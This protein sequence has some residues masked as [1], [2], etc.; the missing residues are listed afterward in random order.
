MKLTPELKQLVRFYLHA[1][2][3]EEIGTLNEVLNDRGFTK[4]DIDTIDHLYETS[5]LPAVYH[6]LSKDNATND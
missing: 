2:T 1:T 5:G 3:G 4:H 6:Y